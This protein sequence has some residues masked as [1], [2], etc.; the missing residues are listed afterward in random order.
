MQYVGFVS[1]PGTRE[2]TF[3]TKEGADEPREFCL[4][5]ANEAFLSHRA[6]YQ[7]AAEICALRLRRELDGAANHPSESH[8]TITDAEL[9]EYRVAHTPPSK[10]GFMARR[11]S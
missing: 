11:P 10:L 4:T 9:E 6:R 1:T 5:I 8:Y 2:Y 3:R 7:D